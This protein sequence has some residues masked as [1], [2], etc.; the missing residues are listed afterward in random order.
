MHTSNYGI[1]CTESGE[2]QPPVVSQ[3]PMRFEKKG[4]SKLTLKH[5]LYLLHNSGD[6]SDNC[7]NF[8]EISGN[9]SAICNHCEC[10]LNELTAD[11]WRTED[12]RNTPPV[13]TKMVSGSYALSDLVR[14]TYGDAIPYK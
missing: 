10:Y 9:S 2:V 8:R 6:S 11:G 12:I 14:E 3:T 5:T 13:F 4:K 7:D 1:W